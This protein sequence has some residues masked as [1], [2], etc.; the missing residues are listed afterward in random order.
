MLREVWLG[1]LFLERLITFFMSENTSV[2]TA[3]ELLDT[4]EADSLYFQ[5]GFE[6]ML[7]R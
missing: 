2:S 3:V 5:G 7:G 6:G 4:N 1:V